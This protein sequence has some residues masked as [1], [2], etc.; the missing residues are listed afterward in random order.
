MYKYDEKDFYKLLMAFCGEDVVC[1]GR[2][3]RIC[4][5][6]MINEAVARGYIYECDY[7]EGSDGR[8]KD[9]QYCISPEGKEARDGHRG[10]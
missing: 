8:E 5:E 3:L 2:L 9:I 7:C 10:R 1:R 4:P 6:D